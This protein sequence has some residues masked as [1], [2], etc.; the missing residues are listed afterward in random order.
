[1]SAPP[2]W[3]DLDRLLDGLSDADALR[4]VTAVMDALDAESARQAAL[5]K[6]AQAR[7]SK[8]GDMQDRLHKRHHRLLWARDVGRMIAVQ[9]RREPFTWESVTWYATLC[10][11]EVTAEEIVCRTVAG[12]GP[13]YR[14]RVR[15]DG[16][17]PP[18]GPYN[19]WFLP[20]GQVRRIL[21]GTAP[22]VGEYPA[23]ETAAARR[24]EAAVNDMRY[25]EDKE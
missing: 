25:S 1:M 8:I 14:C 6:L 5:V 3:A 7:I 22:R 4:A 17:F 2:T 24:W 21:A 13:A 23:Y 11:L 9:K 12:R 19:D 18:D 10:V 15:A 16:A 20:V